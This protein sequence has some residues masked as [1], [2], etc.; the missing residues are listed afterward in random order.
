MEHP[1][2]AARS[3]T[4]GADEAMAKREKQWTELGIEDLVMP[5]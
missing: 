4:A 1:E 2:R 3:L 5:T